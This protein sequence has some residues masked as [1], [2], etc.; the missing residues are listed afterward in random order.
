MITKDTNKSVKIYVI[1]SFFSTLAIII[2]TGYSNSKGVP[3]WELEISGVTLLLTY[4]AVVSLVIERAVEVIMVAWRGPKKKIL[5]NAVLAT[6]NK[7]E[8]VENEVNAA[9]QAKATYSA[10]TR[11]LSLITAL[12]LGILVS[13]IGVRVL[14]PLVDPVGLKAMGS[15]QKSIFVATDAFV[16]G[17]LLGGGADGIHNIL[18]TFLKYVNKRKEMIKLATLALQ[19][20][21]KE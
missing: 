5:E 12:G 14:E 8:P 9:Y 18:D 1:L 11:S 17:A 10:E 20:H 4:L 21:G 7:K 16:T 15:F 13:A 2:I 3:F 6:T 19:K